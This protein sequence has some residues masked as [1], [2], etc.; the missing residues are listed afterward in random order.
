MES[1]LTPRRAALLLAVASGLTAASVLSPAPTLAHALESSLERMAGL[2]RTLELQSRFST[3]MPAAGAQVSLVSPSGA[4]LALGSTD[5][6]GQLRFALPDAVD[7]SWEVRVDQGPGHRDY[8]ELPLPAAAAG[9]LSHRL[10][11]VLP[12]SGLLAA[13]GASALLLL[14]AVVVGCNRRRGR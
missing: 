1:L 3:G 7:A 12:A 10:R 9:Q 6:E 13:S 14:G 11:S 5:A 2:N 4:S 8:L